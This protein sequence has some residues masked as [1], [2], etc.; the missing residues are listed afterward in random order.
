MFDSSSEKIRINCTQCGAPITFPEGDHSVKCPYCS[1]VLLLISPQ[2]VLKYYLNTEL[3]E[4]SIKFVTEGACKRLRVP[5]PTQFYDPKLYYLPYWRF[6]G[7]HYSLLI[8]NDRYE[9][10]DGT[11]LETE[12]KVNVISK[13]FDLNFPGTNIETFRNIFMGIRSRTLELCPTMPEHLEGVAKIIQPDILMDTAREMAYERT[14]GIRNQERAFYNEL[15]GEVLTLVYMPI[16]VSPFINKEGMFHLVI[17]GLAKKE[18]SLNK[19]E[20]RGI[21]ETDGFDSIASQ[22]I[23]PHHCPE[24]GAD[25]PAGGSA[26]T[27]HCGN[28]GRGWHLQQNG[29]AQKE[30]LFAKH[31]GFDD[32]SYYPFWQFET[33]FAH[34]AE[35][36]TYQSAMAIIGSSLSVF[37]DDS[38]DEIFKFYIP[39]FKITNPHSAWKFAADLTRCQ[40]DLEYRDSMNVKTAPC[41]LEEEEAGEFAR[42]VWY[43]LLS[44]SSKARFRDFGDVNSVPDVYFRPGKIVYLPMKEDGIFLR[45]QISGSGIQK[46]GVPG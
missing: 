32:V 20:W 7:A 26:I 27:F 38:S 11:I 19:G 10:E 18:L 21:A 8:D 30:F 14:G 29:L 5:L 28:C 37:I 46:K 1:K 45:E 42:A 35:L 39:G 12:P 9:F 25:L 36:L 41:S 43:Y 23:V 2:R 22:K 4:R 33:T 3:D 15:I 44:C 6:R 40:P 24:C 31:E 34:G 17:D 16:W 13:P